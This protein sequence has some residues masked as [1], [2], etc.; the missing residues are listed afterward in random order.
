MKIIV[1]ANCKNSPKNLKVTEMTQAVLQADKKMVDSLYEEG[2]DALK[3]PDL[4]QI[5]EVRI[6]TAISHGKHASNLCQ[7]TADG[8]IRHIG[9]FFEFTTHK[10]EKYSTILVMQD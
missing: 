2:F 6:L 9:M 1:G 4:S 5:D 8:A 10:A 3:L 7:Y